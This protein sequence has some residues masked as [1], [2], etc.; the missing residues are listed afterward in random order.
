[1]PMYVRS[2]Q[3]LL[4]VVFSS[5][6]RKPCCQIAVCRPHIGRSW[7]GRGLVL[8]CSHNCS[9]TP[10]LVTIV[11]CCCPVWFSTVE[12]DPV[13][14]GAVASALVWFASLFVFVATGPAVWS[15]L[16]RYILVAN[17]PTGIDRSLHGHCKKASGRA[18]RSWTSLDLLVL[19]SPLSPSLPLSIV[20]PLSLPP[21]FPSFSVSLWQRP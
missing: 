3:L 7:L 19:L 21:S 15:V 13:W 14:Y 12:L 17:L 1:M 5:A 20:L 4:T 2:A 11:C 10:G 8:I 6:S 9:L 18:G 16:E